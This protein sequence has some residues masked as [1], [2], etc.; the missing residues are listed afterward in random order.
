MMSNVGNLLQT[1]IQ[2]AMKS[3]K[4]TVNKSQKPYAEKSLFLLSQCTLDKLLSRHR[5]NKLR[6]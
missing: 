5:I 6:E 2:A 3:T 4:P 1:Q